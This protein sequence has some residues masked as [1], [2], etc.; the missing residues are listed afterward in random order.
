LAAGRRGRHARVGRARDD[1]FR[2]VGFPA[3]PARPQFW[4]QLYACRSAS[5]RWPSRSRSTIERSRSARSSSTASW[6]W[7]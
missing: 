5:L 1:L 7:R 6:W 4:S 3:Q 2:D